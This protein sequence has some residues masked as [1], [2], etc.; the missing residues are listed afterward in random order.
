MNHFDAEGAEPESRSQRPGE[1]EDPMAA[2]I[3]DRQL[4]RHLDRPPHWAR[5]QVGL[6]PDPVTIAPTMPARRRRE[7]QMVFR[8]RRLVTVAVLMT[9]AF[10]AGMLLAIAVFSSPAGG[11]LTEEARRAERTTYVVQ[12]G[13]TLWR[14]AE[15]MAPDHDPRAVVDAITEARGTSTIVPGELITWPIE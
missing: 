15:S 4:D 1:S 10:A 5:L 6:Q 7:R 11:S 14:V 9:L 8:R 13:D 3:A 2:L 12:P